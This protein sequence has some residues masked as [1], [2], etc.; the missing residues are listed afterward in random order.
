VR[1]GRL[2]RRRGRPVARHQLGRLFARR[3]AWFE[4]MMPFA[5]WHGRLELGRK[6]IIY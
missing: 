4:N 5:E 3:W 6:Q 2:A 1:D